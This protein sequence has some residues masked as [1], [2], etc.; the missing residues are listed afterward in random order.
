MAGGG[1]HVAPLGISNNEQARVGCCLRDL[2]E[3]L[4]PVGAEALEAGQLGLGRHTVLGG[5]CDDVD[6]EVPGT[7]RPAVHTCR[8][9]IEP[10]H[11]LAA[12]RCDALGE[13]GAEG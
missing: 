11:D 2:L 9:G 6:A 8:V 10:E 13:A 5:P 12:A 3:C 7:N 1:I 4:P